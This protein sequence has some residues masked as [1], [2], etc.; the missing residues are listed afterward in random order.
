LED[1]IVVDVGAGLRRACVR[2]CWWR[3]ALEAG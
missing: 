2:V 1:F 3:R